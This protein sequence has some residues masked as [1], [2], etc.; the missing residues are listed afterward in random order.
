MNRL[1]KLFYHIGRVSYVAR[2]TILCRG[3]PGN[4]ARSEWQHLQRQRLQWQRYCTKAVV[5]EADVKDGM[6]ATESLQP[7]SEI[8]ATRTITSVLNLFYKYQYRYGSCDVIASFDQIYVNSKSTIGKSVVLSKHPKFHLLCEFA[9]RKLHNFS[10]DELLEL[11]K[12]AVKIKNLLG[13][14]GGIQLEHLLN[15]TT[16]TLERSVESLTVDNLL[17][18]LE[19]SMETRLK[20]KVL[21][22]Q[23]ID[24]LIPAIELGNNPSLLARSFYVC[25][26]FG[27]KSSVIAKLE[28]WL[29]HNFNQLSIEQI[30]KVSTAF[31]KLNRRCPELRELLG[32][33]AAQIGLDSLTEQQVLSLTKSYTY[34]PLIVDEL[35][36]EICK[37]IV[38]NI[39]N[40]S[41]YSIGQIARALSSMRYY[42]KSLADVIESR[43]MD[44]GYKKN[45]FSIQSIGDILYAFARWNH[46]PTPLLLR[47]I[48]SRI[49]RYIK[50]SKNLIYPPLITSIWALIVLDV[51]PHRIIAEILNDKIA[52]G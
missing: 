12:S 31:H 22:R 45:A 38:K 8:H 23:F 25:A 34:R 28:S 47:K 5:Q 48:I 29:I 11:L 9:R 32:Q 16:L 33:R 46:S 24:L 42:D 36:E 41:T 6:V 17:V 27:V 50:S 43:M 52:S 13:D 18:I 21:S 44:K 30:C 4:I 19:C 2:T 10:I 20:L 14:N 49:E 37:Y 39:A 3:S 1:H 51:Y 7:F 40:I 35:F 15:H 26:H